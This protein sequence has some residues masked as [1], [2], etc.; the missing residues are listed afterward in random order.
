MAKQRELLTGYKNRILTASSGP[1]RMV[2][3]YS[4]NS[5]FEGQN[6]THLYFDET[7]SSVGTAI[8]STK[9]FYRVQISH[10]NEN[11]KKSKISNMEM[12]TLSVLK[13]R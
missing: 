2:F 13:R 6:G 11:T 9:L 12:E 5:L 1:G 10:R 7:I 8:K 3:E 4:I